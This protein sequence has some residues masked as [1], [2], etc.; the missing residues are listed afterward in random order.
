MEH[1]R[2]STISNEQAG[3]H[4]AAVVCRRAR[5][6]S[7][8]RPSSPPNEAL[9]IA[10]TLPP[11]VHLVA[12]HNVHEEEDK[13]TSPAG[14]THHRRA[15]RR[16]IR[17]IHHEEDDA[18]IPDL[19]RAQA[20][21]DH[22]G[23]TRQVFLARHQQIQLNPAPIV[24]HFRSKPKWIEGKGAQSVFFPSSSGHPF[25]QMPLSSFPSSA[26]PGSVDPGRS[27]SLPSTPRLHADVVSARRCQPPPPELPTFHRPCY[28]LPDAPC[29]LI[30]TIRLLPAPSIN[31][32]DCLA[33]VGSKAPPAYCK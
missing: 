9:G 29:H 6:S 20:D 12:G 7:P 26:R 19:L 15:S 22:S 17:V 1:L 30:A 25:S 3:S 28:P 33:R 14:E 13:V 31:G 32:H 16:A 21:A 2:C 10:T 23:H 8:S 4:G 5:P 11:S 18:H 24:A 27:S